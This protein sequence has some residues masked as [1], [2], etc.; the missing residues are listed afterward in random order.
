[1][2]C[3]EGPFSFILFLFFIAG[4]MVVQGI[5]KGCVGNGPWLHTKGWRWI[6]EYIYWFR[7]IPVDAMLSDLF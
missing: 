3:F 2:I 5:G 7:M 1:M 4:V 6:H